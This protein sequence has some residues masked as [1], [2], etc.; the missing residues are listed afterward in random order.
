MLAFFTFLHTSSNGEIWMTESRDR[1][2]EAIENGNLATVKQIGETEPNLLH[3]SLL[4]SAGRSGYPMTQAA[5]SG[6]AEI[7]AYLILVTSS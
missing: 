1:L 4:P 5:V 2:R 6:H 3:E 7:L